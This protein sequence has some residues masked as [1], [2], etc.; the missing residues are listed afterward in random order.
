M[1]FSGWPET[2]LSISLEI[3]GSSWFS[4]HFV[5]IWG[6]SEQFVNSSYSYSIFIYYQSAIDSLLSE[7]K[8]FGFLK[9]YAQGSFIKVCR[10]IAW[11]IL[12]WLKNS[13]LQQPYSVNGSQ[14]FQTV[15][16][17]RLLKFCLQAFKIVGT[18]NY[19]KLDHSNSGLACDWSREVPTELRIEIARTV[20]SGLVQGYLWLWI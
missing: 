19:I 15:F 10:I 16:E 11:N 5:Q 4:G 3:S 12:M 7:L 2:V 18:F 14:K 13:Y 8:N 20:V 1:T 17:F 6:I 9:F